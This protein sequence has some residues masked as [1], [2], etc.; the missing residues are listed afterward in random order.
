MLATVFWLA[1]SAPQA[2]YLF[3]VFVPITVLLYIGLRRMVPRRLRSAMAGGAR[4]A[5]DDAGCDRLHDRSPAAVTCHSVK[6]TFAARLDRG[7]G[8]GCGGGAIS[9]TVRPVVLPG[10]EVGLRRFQ[11]PVNPEIAVSQT[12]AMTADGLHG[13]EFQ[14]EAVGG[15][16]SGRLTY[17]LMEAGLEWCGRASSRW[18]GCCLRRRTQWNSSQSRI[19]RTRCIVSTWRRRGQSP[20][21][22]SPSG[23]RRATGIRTASCRSTGATD[24]LTLRSRLWHQAGDPT[25]IG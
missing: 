19:Q 16:P 13:F 12:F 24:G 8:A 20:R 25:G 17:E 2:R 6:Y 9:L 11:V 21:S 3:P 14:P 15:A 7:L 23:R 18:R 4:G 10:D 5:A 1:P 22:G